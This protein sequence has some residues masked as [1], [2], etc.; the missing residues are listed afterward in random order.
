MFVEIYVIVTLGLM[1]ITSLISYTLGLY[2]GYYSG[3]A[4]ASV[5]VSREIFNGLKESSEIFYKENKQEE[6]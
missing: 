6:K 2:R 4:L 1:I 5:E 3:Y